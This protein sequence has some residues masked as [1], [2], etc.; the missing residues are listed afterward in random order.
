MSKIP[1]IY[2]TVFVQY[3][4]LRLD[5]SKLTLQGVKP[6]P[7]CKEVKEGRAVTLPDGRKV[8]CACM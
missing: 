4:Y 5:I 6:G 8:W 7:W 1:P 2:I 3:F